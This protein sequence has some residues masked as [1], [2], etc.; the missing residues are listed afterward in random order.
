MNTHTHTS[1]HARTLAPHRT[2]PHGNKLALGSPRV[3]RESG[4]SRASWARPLTSALARGMR[5]GHMA[6]A[7]ARAC[8][9]KRQHVRK[10]GTFYGA[11]VVHSHRWQIILGA[12]ERAS[13]R[14]DDLHVLNL[15]SFIDHTGATMRV[16]LGRGRMRTNG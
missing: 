8:A 14:R 11:E 7:R 3:A 5:R 10:H 6:S 9:C 16:S 13:P 2:A 4:T 1:T 15:I 12:R